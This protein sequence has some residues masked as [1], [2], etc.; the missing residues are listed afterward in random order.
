MTTLESPDQQAARDLIKGNAVI[1]MMAA[2]VATVP[3]AE[4]ADK[5]G[6]P[7]WDFIQQANR[8]FDKAEAENAG[9][10]AYQPYPAGAPR[11]LGLVAEAVL[12]ERAAMREAVASAMAAPG[13]SPESPEVTGII[14]RLRAGEKPVDIARESGALP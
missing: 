13:T 9:K 11:H 12:A 4:L 8:T 6:T 2:G 7:R 1:A 10:A 3:L 14:E 5:D